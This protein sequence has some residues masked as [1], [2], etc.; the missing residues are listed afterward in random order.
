MP[1]NRDQIATMA[2][3]GCPAEIIAKRL[4]VSARHIR[5]LLAEAG[6]EAGTN[7]LIGGDD[8]WILWQQYRAAGYSYRQIAYRFGLSHSAIHTYF[9]SPRMEGQML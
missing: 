3:A 1:L 8:E 5:R 4:H 7:T 6:T 2:R 9:T